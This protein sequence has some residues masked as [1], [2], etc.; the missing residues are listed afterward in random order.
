MT[1][2]I[3][4]TLA[5]LIIVLIPFPFAQGVDTILFHYLKVFIK[6]FNGPLMVLAV[7]T[8]C[9]S[10]LLSLYAL[11]K[12]DGWIHHHRLT[13]KLF[14]TTPFYVVN[15]FLG[16]AI[17]LCVLFNIGPQWLISIDTGKTMVSLA[18]QLA[19][20]VPMMFLFQTLILEF[21]AMEFLGQ[22]VGFLLKPLFKV[23]EACAVSIITAWV[24]PGNAAIM[25]TEEFFTQGFFTTK[26]AIIVGSQF[27]TGSVGWIV[28]VCSV[29]GVIE[30][31]G[32]IFL[33]LTL[34]GIIVA[35][36]SVRIP[37]ISLYPNTYATEPKKTDHLH[38]NRLIAGLQLAAQRAKHAGLSNFIAKID[39]MG[40][41]VF[42]LTPIIVCWGTLALIISIYTP[43]LAIVSLPV[44]WILSLFG[45]PQAKLTASAIMSGLAD[46]YLPV[47]LGQ[48]LHAVSS[49]IIV[50]TMSIMQIIY[51]SETATLLLSTNKVMKLSHVIL[52]FLERTF[53]SLPFIIL[54]AQWVAH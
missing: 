27:A 2:F 30:Y 49:K 50:A 29:L 45:M 33:A 47:I 10:A 38:T 25:A 1:K 36:V 9:A 31:V 26:E 44:E 43:F 32:P 13:Q 52:I 8:I 53:I 18:T 54:F 48:G 20:L 16:A 35:F 22:L 15:R 37:P 51:L 39:N 14:V 6:A 11:I 34:I 41:Y 3:F 24:G 7:L 19:I 17:S 4:A 12:K 40:F 28:L 5:G 46:N 23:S 42:W 21:G